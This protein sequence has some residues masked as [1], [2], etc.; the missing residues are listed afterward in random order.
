MSGSPSKLTVA[1]GCHMN[2]ANNVVAAVPACASVF[3]TVGKH[4]QGCQANYN[5]EKDVLNHAK[6]ATVSSAWSKW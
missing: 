1:H 2:S 3:R 4:A 5:L 6:G